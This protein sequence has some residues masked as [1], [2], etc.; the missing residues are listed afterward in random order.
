MGEEYGE[1][2]PFL[3][4]VSHGDPALVEAVREGRRREFAAFDWAG[5]VP[6]PQSEETYTRSRLDWDG[7]YEPHHAALRRLYA[8]LLRLRKNEPALSPGAARVK[9]SHDESAGWITLHSVAGDSE[10]VGVFNFAQQDTGVRLPDLPCR[11]VLST[12][13]SRYGG[14][15]RIAL[16]NGRVVLPPLSAALFRRTSQ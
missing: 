1:T 8:D 2:N 13:D 7:A 11:Q 14:Q 10:L 9:V 6:D 4:F 15:D 3:Y 12:D 16:H 5:E